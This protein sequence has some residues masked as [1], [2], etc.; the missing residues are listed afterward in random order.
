M[1]FVP[2]EFAKEFENEFH[3]KIEPL[4]RKFA[5]D[6]QIPY[7]PSEF[8]LELPKSIDDFI[9]NFGEDEDNE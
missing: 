7:E 8:T 2:K 9:G 1:N 5:E 4:L 3:E 6:F